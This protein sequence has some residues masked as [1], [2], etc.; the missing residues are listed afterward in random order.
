MR[1]DHIGR[2][3]ITAAGLP[4]LLLLAVTVPGH[5]QT[6][7]A[8][9]D[10][11]IGRIDGPEEYTFARVA[12]VAVGA[13]GTIWILDRGDALIK[14]YDPSGR[15][16]NSVGGSG[17]G[18][19]EF[20]EPSEIAVHGDTLAVYDPRQ[21]RLT[22]FRSDGDLLETAPVQAGGWFTGGFEALGDGSFLLGI[23]AGYGLPPDPE[24]DGKAWLLRIG[25]DG[26]VLDTLLVTKGPDQLLERTAETLISASAPFQ[27]R[28]VWAVATDGTIAF[29]RGESYE[30]GL[31]RYPA[32]PPAPGAR[33]T[34]VGTLRR[35][36]PNRRAT[37][38][39]V[40]AYREKLLGADGLDEN[41]RRAYRRL[42][43]DHDFPDTWP[44]FRQL[45][46]D[47]RG[48]LWVEREWPS[49]E[50]G[51]SLWEVFAPDGKLVGSLV[52]EGDVR[53]RA[54]D[55]SR[56]Y[57]IEDDEFGV[58]Y[59]KRLRFDGLGPVAR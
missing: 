48:R 29:G 52:V 16:L 26:R 47:D 27:R 8:A 13:D 21:R 19:G 12:D 23:V 4:L 54:I 43:A 22:L 37:R 35:E 31:Y 28:P 25:S 40:Q 5:G 36:S 6:P 24:R 38:R 57:G 46:F 2:G 51:H 42:L 20:R 3:G 10:L 15:F 30:I 55:G 32:G 45:R 11:S 14:A 17:S 39:D 33:A 49:S 1:A 58:Q 50:L 53:V 56:L 18:P 7:R 34:A 41:V 44:A 59:V 9:Q